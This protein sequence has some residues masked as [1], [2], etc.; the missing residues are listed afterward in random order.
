MK[1]YPKVRDK[2]WAKD[3]YSDKTKWAEA[4]MVEQFYADNQNKCKCPWEKK[5]GKIVCTCQFENKCH[6]KILLR[7]IRME[8][9]LQVRNLNLHHTCGFH[10][11][12][13]KV[14]S[15]FLADRARVKLILYGD[16]AEEYARVF[17]Y[18][19]AVLKYNLGS[20]VVV[21]IEGVERP[22]PIFQKIYICFEA[23]KVGFKRGCRPII[24]LDGCHWKGAFPGMIL[25]AVSKDDNNNIYPVAWAVVE[26]IEKTKGKGLTLMSD[27]K[28]GLLEAFVVVTPNAEIRFCVRHIWANFKLKFGG[29]AFKEHFWKSARSTTRADF[30]LNMAKI[31]ELSPDA[32]KYLDAIPP[33]HWLARN[34]EV[35]PLRLDIWEV[36]YYNDRYVVNLGQITCTCFRWELTGI[37]CAHAWACIIKKRLRPEDFVDSVYSKD[38]YLEAYTLTINPMSGMKQWEKRPDMMQPKPPIMRK[39]PGR[40]SHKKRKQELGE[41]EEA[42]KQQKQKKNPKCSNC[43]VVGHYKNKCKN[44]APPK[45]VDKGG[46][47]PSMN[48][49][50]VLQRQ[51]NWD[52]AVKKGKIDQATGT[53]TSQSTLS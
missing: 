48:P 38:K 8:D 27:R 3:L 23:C 50:N 24:G 44:L 34:C 16:S 20:S 28:K 1:A 47:P 15:E 10:H 45:E 6:F 9:T 26:D 21:V 52:R 7:Q 41:R 43:G 25:V 17:D 18:G 5:H 36:D 13:S 4:F 31:N 14:T 49:W 40:P 33:N 30:E 37:P 32:F 53:P 42:V 46:R 12:S 35:I 29:E 22:P 19:F 39:M 11:E 2:K 51:K